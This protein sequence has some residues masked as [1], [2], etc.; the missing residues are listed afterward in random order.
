MVIP[1]SEFL[2]ATV[3]FFFE[4]A[5]RPVVG[6]NLIRSVHDEIWNNGLECES[7]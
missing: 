5:L 4:R 6:A 1:S 2:D 3:D 7:R